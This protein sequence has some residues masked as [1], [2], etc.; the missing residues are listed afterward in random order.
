MV[1]SANTA[2]KAEVFD[3]RAHREPEKKNDQ[4]SKLR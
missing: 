1:R 3:P 4:T 2:K